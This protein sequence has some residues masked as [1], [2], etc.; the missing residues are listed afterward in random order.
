M[1]AHAV[2]LTEPPPHGAA[3]PFQKQDEQHDGI[4]PPFLFFGVVP[5]S[6]PLSLITIALRVKA[7]LKAIGR[8]GDLAALYPY[9]KNS[10][11]LEATGA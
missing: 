5:F 9:G 3:L 2:F 7:A 4:Y 10:N 8:G 11:K 6:I 1:T